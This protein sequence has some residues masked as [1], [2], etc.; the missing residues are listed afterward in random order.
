MSLA[1]PHLTLNFG[2]TDRQ[3]AAVSQIYANDTQ[4]CLLLKRHAC[5][6]DLIGQ[7]LSD[8]ALWCATS[9]HLYM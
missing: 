6:Y 1:Q 4:A 9:V 8:P 5:A 7:L 3:A 2:R